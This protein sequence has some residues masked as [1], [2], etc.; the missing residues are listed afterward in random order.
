MVTYTIKEEEAVFYPGTMA[1]I[2]Q[3]LQ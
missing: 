2:H 3:Q 1:S